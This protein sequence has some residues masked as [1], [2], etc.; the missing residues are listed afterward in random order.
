[1]QNS[2]IQLPD[3]AIYQLSLSATYSFILNHLWVCH[4]NPFCC[5][6]YNSSEDALIDGGRNELLQSYSFW[7][8]H[9]C[10]WLTIEPFEPSS[11]IHVRVFVVAILDDASN[12][13][14][15]AS[16]GTKTKLHATETKVLA[17]FALALEEV[18]H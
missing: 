13:K 10:C 11:A 14:R 8:R 3:H 1:M 5:A 15:L 6:S 16:H 17:P 4:S 2:P 18:L 9:S 7:G 12:S